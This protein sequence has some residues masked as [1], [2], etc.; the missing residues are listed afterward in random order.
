[1]YQNQVVPAYVTK[2]YSYQPQVY[3]TAPVYQ[4][5]IPAYQPVV[6]QKRIQF[7]APQV[8]KLHKTKQNISIYWK[9]NCYTNYTHCALYTIYIYT[10][11]T[12]LHFS[13]FTMHY[14][15]YTLYMHK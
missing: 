8:K 14:T 10:I 11:H 12:M 4:Y 9:K 5:Q 13:I 3:Q 15:L 2:T 1:M 6:Y 7:T